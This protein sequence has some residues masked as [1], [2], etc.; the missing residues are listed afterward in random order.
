MKWLL[1]VVLMSSI[2]LAPAQAQAVAIVAHRG[3]SHDAPENTVAA[4]REGWKQGADAVELDIYLSKDGR[5]VVMH[6]D[7]TKRTAGVDKRVVGQTFG[8]LR[9]LDAG[10]WKGGAFAGEKIPT[11]EE[12]IATIPDGK[13]LFIEI[14]CGSEI[15]PTLQQTLKASGKPDSQFVIIGFSH[16]TMQAAKQTMPYHKV[17]WLSSFKKDEQ[18]GALTPTLDELIDKAKAANLDGLDLS[19]KWPLDAASIARIKA[20]GLECH[21]WTVDN[22][23]VARRLAAAGVDGITTNRPAFIREELKK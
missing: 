8:E 14:K 10:R 5:I 16:S 6:D 15:L 21:V 1:T 22:P 11:L 13:P 3:A 17:F 12:A 23:D 7:N 20:A 4:F 9:Q 19:Y 2:L 18:T